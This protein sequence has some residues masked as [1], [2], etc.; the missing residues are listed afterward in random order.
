MR[1]FE[2]APPPP[3]PLQKIRSERQTDRAW[4]NNRQKEKKKKKRYR[5]SDTERENMTER[6]RKIMRD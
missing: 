3:L 2:L 1:L 6:K 5:E 4:I